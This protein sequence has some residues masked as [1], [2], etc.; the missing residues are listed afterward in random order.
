MGKNSAIKLWWTTSWC[1]FAYLLLASDGPEEEKSVSERE[2]TDSEQEDDDENAPFDQLIQSARNQV[3]KDL[4]N[5]IVHETDQDALNKRFKKAFREKYKHALLWIHRLG[6][7]P[8]HRKIVETA[9]DLRTELTD[10]DYEESIV[11]SMSK[12]KYLLNQL[13]PEY[14]EDDEMNTD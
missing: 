10:S 9:K 6:Q 2:D 5:G 14:N 7:N 11:A 1:F 13:V 4:E 12:R 8:T 3:E